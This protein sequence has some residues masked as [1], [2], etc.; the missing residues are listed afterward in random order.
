MLDN[1][2]A[3]I[4]PYDLIARKGL[5]Q[6]LDSHLVMLGISVCG[7]QYSS[8]DDKEIGVGGRQALS[9]VIENRRSHRERHEIIG[10]AITRPQS[11]KFLFHKMEF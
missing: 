6:L 10:Q 1:Q 3:A 2:R 4:D 5:L 8:V 11:A 7:H 9:L